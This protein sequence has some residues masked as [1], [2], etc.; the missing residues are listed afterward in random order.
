L[1][2]AQQHFATLNAEDMNYL[3]NYIVYNWATPSNWS[4]NQEF[5][6]YTVNNTF[7]SQIF[8]ESYA[9]TF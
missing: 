2:V 3:G 1:T 4:A 9:D 5:F 7:Y 6:R 8:E